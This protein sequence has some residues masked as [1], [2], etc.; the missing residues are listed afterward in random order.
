MENPTL[1][2]P[3]FIQILVQKY[4]NTIHSSTKYTPQDIILP[5]I[6]SSKIIEKVYQNLIQKQSQDSKYH[7]KSRKLIQIVENKPIYEKKLKLN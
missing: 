3:D 7:N 6:D 2:P 1:S 5:S 4:N